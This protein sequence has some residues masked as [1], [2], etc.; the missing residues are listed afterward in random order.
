[1]P[2]LTFNIQMERNGHKWLRKKMFVQDSTSV[3]K[4]S[5]SQ[6][7]VIRKRKR[8]VEEA[9]ITYAYYDAFR[10]WCHVIHVFSFRSRLLMM[11]FWKRDILNEQVE[12]C[13]NVFFLSHSYVDIISLFYGMHQKFRQNRL[14]FFTRTCEWEM[15]W[16]IVPSKCWNATA[17]YLQFQHNCATLTDSRI[18]IRMW[19]AV[20]SECVLA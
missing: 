3:F 9:W 8:K 19:L 6:K 18:E 2:L 11:H 15:N 17:F 14:E 20:W 7:C 12:S 1:M 16:H 4:I 13:T 10:R 5:C